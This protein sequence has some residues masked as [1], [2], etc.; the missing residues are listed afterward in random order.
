MRPLQ[1]ST[2]ALSYTPYKVA[3]PPP[4][5]TNML[6]GVAAGY[7]FMGSIVTTQLRLEEYRRAKERGAS[8]RELWVNHVL[9]F[10]LYLAVGAVKIPIYIVT[11]MMIEGGK[12]LHELGGRKS[13]PPFGDRA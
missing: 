10:P 1:I 11:S 8:S 6:I 5:R 13:P 12:S 3:N 2:R 4:T 9:P 7:V